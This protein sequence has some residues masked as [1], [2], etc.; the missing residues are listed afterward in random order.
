MAHAQGHGTEVL[1]SR[2][3]R[4]RLTTVS[5][6][7]AVATILFVLVAGPRLIGPIALAIA[8]LA[9]ALLVGSLALVRRPTGERAWG[10]FKFTAPYLG[11]LFALLALNAVVGG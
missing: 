3:A 4:R 7:L 9:L 2:R 8:V 1:I 11:L 5:V 6:V 10:L